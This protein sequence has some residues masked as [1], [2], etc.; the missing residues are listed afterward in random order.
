[1][2]S[3]YS[4]QK[5]TTNDKSEIEDLCKDIWEGDDYLPK[6]FDSWVD[7]KTGEFV[8]ALHKGK[9]VGVGKLTM[10]SP[11]DA[12]LEGLRKL[13][14][15]E[16]KSVGF[17]IM[18]Y[19]IKKLK[20]DN[21]VKTIALSTY[22]HNDEAIR[23]FERLGFV[24]ILTRS[25]KFLD[26]EKYINKDVEIKLCDDLTTNDIELF[27]K[28][29]N[30]FKSLKG[31]ITKDWKVLRYSNEIIQEFIDKGLTLCIKENDDI[32]ALIVWHNAE[33]AASISILDGDRKYLE[34]L[35]HYF[36]KDVSEKGFD[37]IAAFK[38]EDKKVGEILD[39]IGFTSWE[40]ENDFLLFTHP[41]KPMDLEIW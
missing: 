23:L 5:I 33:S 6:R 31:L 38:T 36:I 9:I 25:Y 24:K 41:S 35:I 28:K 11:C 22:I 20:L 19:F 13:P 3:N 15:F 10:N 1:M 30:Y 29:S 16:G 27:L 17:S 4:I 26:R 12:W 40:T 37:H 7:D 32:R 21:S 8:K 2:Q 18:D 39:S 14:S 34:D